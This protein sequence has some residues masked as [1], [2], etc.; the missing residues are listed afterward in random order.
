MNERPES[1][2]P[3]PCIGLW[4]G[5]ILGKL[6]IRNR[7]N[8]LILTLVLVG[9]FLL[10]WGAL[11]CLMEKRGAEEIKRLSAE[12]DHTAEAV[13][14]HFQRSLSLLEILPSTIADDA[15]VIENLRLFGILKYWIGEK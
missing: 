6:N 14:Y 13:T 10:S 8:A 9:W 15:A 2:K 4:F 1:I 3:A 11:S 12:L 7:R 5:T